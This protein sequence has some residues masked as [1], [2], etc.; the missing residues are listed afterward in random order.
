MTERDKALNTTR[1]A[2]RMAKL[3]QTI[4]EAI[5][6][7]AEARLLH[8]YPPSAVLVLRNDISKSKVTIAILT[9]DEVRFIVNT[10]FWRADQRPEEAIIELFSDPLKKRLA[11]RGISIKVSTGGTR[12]N[13]GAYLVL[14]E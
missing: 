11:I 3:N 8:T 9:Y 13:D 6:Q 1:Y 4:A 7:R 12:Y 5:V 10:A 2:S 14:D